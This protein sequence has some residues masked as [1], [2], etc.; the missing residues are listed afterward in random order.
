MPQLCDETY[1]AIKKNFKNK[2]LQ[3]KLNN[4]LKKS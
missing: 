1:M 4:S 3:D 2:D